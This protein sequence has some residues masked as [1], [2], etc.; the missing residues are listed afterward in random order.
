M[1]KKL[2]VFDLDGTVLDTLAD[3]AGALN[4]A[5]REHGFPERTPEQVRLAIGGGLRRMIDRSVPDTVPSERKEPVFRSFVERY[6][7][8][9]MDK[10][11]PYEGVPGL[12]QTL[13]DTGMLLALVTNKDARMAEPLCDTF[14]P[15]M[16]D[17]VVGHTPGLRSKPAPDGVESVLNALSVPAGEA[18]Y[19]GDSEVDAKTAENAGTDSVI[20][21]WGYRTVSELE[22]LGIRDPVP[23][24]ETL[25][26]RLL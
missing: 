6:A 22:N 18:V 19:I 14:F 20:V 16:F 24:P 8:H 12:L 11:E 15:G 9:F 25:L 5:L 23:D 7:S 10:T 4:H 1:T 21:S 3:L 17:L 2:A 13:K 26:S